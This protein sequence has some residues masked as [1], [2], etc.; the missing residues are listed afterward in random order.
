MPAYYLEAL[1]VTLGIILLMAEAFCTTRSKAWVGLCVAVG[2][3]GI[4][5]I[6]FIAIGPQAK[7]DAEWAKW[8]LWNFYHFDPLAKFYKCFALITT[9]FVSLLAVDYRKILARFTEGPESENG[10]GEFYA[11]PVFACAGMM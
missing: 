8:P 2:L 6:T 11:L 9:I 1:T 7:P 10:T 5:A 4:L 3:T